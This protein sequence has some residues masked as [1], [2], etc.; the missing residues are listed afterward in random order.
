M[1]LYEA[2]RKAKTDNFRYFD[3]W[4]YN[5]FADQ[6]NPVY[7]INRFK[8][9]FGGYYSFFAKKMNIDLFQFGTRIFKVYLVI[10]NIKNRLF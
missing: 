1:V 5:H 8:K 3:F 9:G 2:I 10:R 4:G 6:S 7:Y